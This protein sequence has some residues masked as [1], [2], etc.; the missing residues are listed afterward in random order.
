MNIN[1]FT[2]LDSRPIAESRNHKGA[3]Y[4]HKLN[5]EGEKICTLCDKPLEGHPQCSS[6]TALIHTEH[7]HYRCACGGH[8]DLVTNSDK[9]G[10]CKDAGPR[11]FVNWAAIL[12]TTKSKKKPKS[13]PLKECVECGKSFPSKSHSVLYCPPEEGK[14]KSKCAYRAERRRSQERKVKF[15]AECGKPLSIANRYRTYCPPEE[16]KTKSICWYR[17]KLKRERERDMAIKGEN[18]D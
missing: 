4:K 13:N 15:C 5:K 8:E 18:H 14:R 11:K 3:D 17:A 2:D 12:G 10:M 9:C 16:G 1:E 6:C 7:T